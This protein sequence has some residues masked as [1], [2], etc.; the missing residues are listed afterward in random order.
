V[1]GRGSVACAG[2]PG[3][4][5]VVGVVDEVVAS[6]GVDEVAL[7]AQVGGGDGHELTV[8]GRRRHCTGPGH[9]TVPVGCEE[10]RGDQDLRIVAGA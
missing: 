4:E 1:R 7:A 5:D 2:D 8:A 10:R 3:D 9:E 6:E